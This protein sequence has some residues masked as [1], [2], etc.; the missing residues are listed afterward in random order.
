MYNITAI[1]PLIPTSLHHVK[2]M[3]NSFTADEMQRYA[4]HFSLSEVGLD[5]QMRLKNAKVLCVGAGG[6]A[7]PALLYLAAA[8]IG[9]LGIVDDDQ[10]ELSNLQ[11]QILYTTQNVGANKSITAKEKLL[12]LNPHIQINLHETRLTKN[13]VFDL[14]TPY[15]III[16]ATD[17]FH[18]HYLINDACFYLNKP[19]IYASILRFEGQCAVFSAKG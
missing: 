18:S 14:L 11:R 4:K 3:K 15:D 6:L 9:T 13:N 10:I 1:I 5:G 7:S 2:N 19:D 17:N 12:Q 8:G 16:D